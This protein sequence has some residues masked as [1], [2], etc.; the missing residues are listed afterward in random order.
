MYNI[1]SLF[2]KICWFKISQ[3]NAYSFFLSFYLSKR[4]WKLLSF[5]CHPMDYTV[6]GILQ[7]RTMERV[8]F[9]FSRG[10]S[11]TRGQTQV[12]CIA[13]GFFYQLSHQRNPRLIQW[14]RLHNT[15]DPG[16]IPGQGLRSR[17]PQLKILHAA[18]KTQ[19]SQIKNFF[20]FFKGR[21]WARMNIQ[22][23]ILLML[24]ISCVRQV[25]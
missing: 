12:S 20:Y 8:A 17:M 5:F 21:C 14:L 6:H 10:S 1:L 3:R 23:C 16:S 24:L 25:S 9:P 13:G 19:H 7:A 4:K 18:T 15:G 2:L 22:V 11:Q